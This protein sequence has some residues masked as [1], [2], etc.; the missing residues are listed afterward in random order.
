MKEGEVVK[1]NLIEGGKF[2]KQDGII[3]KN[4]IPS[5]EKKFSLSRNLLIGLGIF[6][7]LILIV[8]GIFFINYLNS[9]EQELDLGANIEG[10]VFNEKLNNVF[11]KLEGGSNDKVITKIKFIFKDADG[12]EYFYET[13]EGIKEISIPYK[14]GFWDFIRKPK[15]SGVYDYNINIGDILNLVDFKEIANVVVV[16]E[17]EEDG[18][19]IETPPLDDKPK[20]I[21]SGGNDDNGGYNGPDTGNKGCADESVEVTCSNVFCG[22]KNN[23]CKAP[24]NCTDVSGFLGDGLNCTNGIWLDESKNCTDY[25]DNYW[26]KDYAYNGSLFSD[27]CLDDSNLSEFLCDCTGNCFG[28]SIN[29]TNVTYECNEG[30]VN[31]ACVCTNECVEEGNYCEDD[32][33]SVYNCVLNKTTGC[34]KKEFVEDCTLSVLV[35]SAGECIEETGICNDIDGD[36]YGVYPNFNILNGC[37]KDGRDCNDTEISGVNIHPG[38][39]ESCNGIDDDCSGVADDYDFGQTT[40]GLG[41]CDHTINNCFAGETQTCDPFEGVGVELCDTLRLDEDCDGSDNEECPCD[42]GDSEDCGDNDVGECEFGTATCDING[43][44]GDCIGAIN[45]SPEVCD[46]ADNDCDEMIDEDDLGTILTQNCYEGPIDTEGIGLCI[47]GTQTCTLGSYLNTICAGQILPGVELCDVELLDEDCDD[48]NNEDCICIPGT[49]FPCGTDVG[50]CVSGNYVCQPD[51]RWGEVCEGEIAPVPEVCD[52]LDNDCTGVADDA[53]FGQT[54]CGEGECYNTIDNCIGGL[55]QTC[56]PF[57]GAVPEVC[58]GLL[59]ED[60]DG[61]V[62]NDCEC[63]I[64]S[65]LPCGTDVGLCVSGIYVCQSD[66]TWGDVCEGEIAPVPEVCDGLDNDCNGIDDNNPTDCS[67]D[68]CIAGDCV[69]CIID[70]DCDP[71]NTI[72]CS[73]S[74]TCSAPGN[75]EECGGW[76]DWGC[77]YGDCHNLG[78]CY[79]DNNIWPFANDC[80]DTS[81]VC[82]S[83]S[84]CEDYSDDECAD[85]PCVLI[86]ASGECVFDGTSCITCIDGDSDGWNS[87]AECNYNGEVDCDD[88]N[89]LVYPGAPE[90]CD[91]I[92]NDCNPL[93]GDICDPDSEV[94][95][96]GLDDD[97][98]TYVDQCDADCNLDS[99]IINSANPPY[100][101]IAEICNDE[102]DNDCNGLTNEGCDVPVPSAHWEFEGDYSDSVGPY[103]GSPIINPGFAPGKNGQA[104]SLPN[105]GTSYVDFGDVLDLTNEFTL[106]AWV[107]WED[108]G[109]FSA[110]I[111][112]KEMIDPL[113]PESPHQFNFEIRGDAGKDQLR[114]LSHDLEPN[115]IYSSDNSIPYNQ[116]THVA[117][118]FDGTNRKVFVNGM[119][120]SSDSASGTILENSET[121]KIGYGMGTGD[122]NNYFYGMIDDVM[123]YEE[124]LSEMEVRDIYCAQGGNCQCD[125]TNARWSKDG[126]NPLV[127]VGDS[128]DLIVDASDP[129][130]CYGKLINYTIWENDG[131]NPLFSLL[132][133]D[134]FVLSKI[135]SFDRTN[136]ITELESDY[137]NPEY[138]FTARLV[139]SEEE[140]TSGELIV[141]PCQ[142]NDGDGWNSTLGCNNGAGYDCNDIPGEGEGINPGALETCNTVDD[143]C[144]GIDDNNVVDCAEGE[145]CINGDCVKEEIYYVSKSGAGDGSEGNPDNLEGA[146]SHSY[147]HKGEEITYLLAPGDYGQFIYA[148]E[149]YYESMETPLGPEHKWHTWRSQDSD[150]PATFSV[151]IPCSGSACRAVKLGNEGGPNSKIAYIFDGIKVRGSFNIFSGIG[152]KILNSDLGGDPGKF[153]DFVVMA[154]KTNNNVGDILVENCYL[155]H[156]SIQMLATKGYDVYIKN[157]HFYY[158]LDDFVSLAGGDYFVV[159]GNTFDYSTHVIGVH[160]DG[161]QLYMDATL[162]GPMKNIF[163]RNNTFSRNA[164]QGIFC[165]G[166][167][168]YMNNLVIEYNLIYDNGGVPLVVGSATD[169]IVR[170]NT[171][172]GGASAHLAGNMDFSDNLFV[173]PV[174]TYG[175]VSTYFNSD[176]GHNVYFAGGTT[177]AYTI[178]TPLPTDIILT[179]S[180]EEQINEIFE[181]PSLNDYR[182]KPGSIA[183]SS[184]YPDG[185]AG[186]F[187]CGDSEPREICNVVGDEEGDGDA[188]CLDSD[189]FREMGPYGKICCGTISDCSICQECSSNECDDITASDGY[190]CADPG[191]YCDAGVCCND[192]N[193]DGVCDSPDL[194]TFIDS[195]L[196]NTLDVSSLPNYPRSYDGNTWF[197]RTG[198]YDYQHPYLWTLGFFPGALWEMYNLTSDN[199]WITNAGSWTDGLSSHKDNTYTHDLGFMFSNSNIKA[200]EYT[201]DSS[202]KADAITAAETLALRYKSGAQIIDAA[203]WNPTSFDNR[204]IIDSAMNLELLFWAEKN[205]ANCGDVSCYDIA[206][207][208]AAKMAADIVR[209]DGSTY[210]SVGYSDDGVLQGEATWQGYS[211][212]STWARGQAWGLYGYTMIYRET[213]DVSFLTTAEEIANYFIN[214]LPADYVPYW[215]FD[216]GL[217]DSSTDRDSSAAAIAASGLLELSHVEGLA[218][219]SIKAQ[220]YLTAANNI[221]NSLEANYLSE[222][223]HGILRDGVGNH[224][225]AREGVADE[226]E[227]GVSL[228]YGDMYFVEAINRRDNGFAYDCIGADCDPDPGCESDNECV[229]RG[230]ECIGTSYYDYPD[231]GICLESGT[232]NIGTG[233][234]E[235][236]APIITSNHP[237]CPDSGECVVADSAAWNN[238]VI[239]LEENL[240]TIEFDATVNQTGANSIFALSDGAQNTFGAFSVIVRFDHITNEI[241]AH[242]GGYTND[243]AIPYSADTSYH[244][245]IDTDVMSNTYDVY[246][247]DVQLANDYAFRDDVNNNINKID[248]WAIEAEIGSMEV[249]NVEISESSPPPACDLIDAYWSETGRDPEPPVVEGQIV[250]MIVEGNNNN[251]IGKAITYTIYENDFFWDDLVGTFDSESWTTKRIP[252]GIGDPEY[253]FTATLVED[254]TKTI[255]SVVT[256]KVSELECIDGDKDGYND[257]SFGC[258][259][260]ANVDCVDNNNAIHPGALEVCNGFDDDCN[261]LTDE[262]FSNCVGDEI[263]F[264]GDC[265]EDPCAGK[266]CGDFSVDEPTCLNNGCGLN[267]EWDGV[268]CQK[269]IEVIYYV[270]RDG[271][272]LPRNGNKGNEFTLAEA[273]DHSEAN[274]RSANPSEITYELKGEDYGVFD[275]DGIYDTPG[276]PGDVLLNLIYTGAW[277]T[278]RSANGETAIFSCS[279]NC[280]AVEIG[281]L[282]TSKVYRI[283]YIFDNIK[284]VG[285]FKT[286][287]AFGLK[288][289]NSEIMGT[290]GY[291]PTAYG[292]LTLGSSN[293]ESGDI[294]VDKCYIHH[295]K[296]DG[297][298]VKGFNFHIKNSKMRSPGSDLIKLNGIINLVIENNDFGGVDRWNTLGDDRRSTCCDVNFKDIPECAYRDYNSCSHPDIIQFYNG[299]C[300]NLLIRNN[301]FFGVPVQGI[302]VNSPTSNVIL[303]YN[304]FYDSDYPIKFQTSTSDIVIRY[305]TIVQKDDNLGA[306]MARVCNYGSNIDVYNN[307]FAIPYSGAS[308][309]TALDY[310]DYNIWIAHTSTPSPGPSEPHSYG[311][312]KSTLLADFKVGGENVFVDYANDN[313]APN[314]NGI[315]CDKNLFPNGV[316]AFPCGDPTCPGIDTSCG[317]DPDNCANCNLND[318]CT[319]DDYYDYYCDNNACDVEIT[320]NDPQ[321]TGL[322]LGTINSCGDSYPDCDDCENMTGCVEDVFRSYTK[323]ENYACVYEEFRFNTEIGKCN[324]GHDSDCDDLTDCDDEDDCGEDDACGIPNDYVAHWKFNGVID[325]VI[326]DETG[327][328]DGDLIN[329]AV[330]IDDVERG[331]KVLSLPNGGTSY[332]DMGD[333]LDMEGP[334]TLSTWVNWE[335][336]SDPYAG[337]IIGKEIGSGLQYNLEIR[338]DNG[339]KLRFISD[340]GANLYSNDPISKNTW[341]H[342]VFSFDGSV[343]KFYVNGVENGQGGMSGLTANDDS[344]K[345][346]YGQGTGANNNYLYGMVDDVAIYDRALSG[347]EIMDELYCKQ[348][349]SCVAS[350]NPLNGISEWFDNLLN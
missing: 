341:T 303:E 118:S 224:G 163:I 110:T 228:I 164:V 87:T 41:E 314:Q 318:G 129:D 167:P 48:L 100:V 12:N 229:C 128:V 199:K 4:S 262:E 16:F 321:C 307:L 153:V 312:D 310:H 1:T 102:Y 140:F 189:C 276:A 82:L 161:I 28:D 126:V 288:L 141:S 30:C 268:A 338:K 222:W 250:E 247:D 296:E 241:Q 39:I 306:A 337:T 259:G 157:N 192:D 298:S 201:G 180:V 336:S 43:V 168:T 143:N 170:H 231:F 291:L 115:T 239:P 145:S 285:F 6:G 331:S 146:R 27:V 218:G 248:N 24:V 330:I 15:F 257:T 281:P 62:D 263:C 105:G 284:V 151:P 185:Y 34:N 287:S 18:D 215:D 202:Y 273:M 120:D 293:Y 294:L 295:V 50:L 187:P 121:L 244:F 323:C 226:S 324:D 297:I 8:I 308:W 221:L 125:L 3:L 246:V 99:N 61:R 210:H 44:M 64:G 112:G 183:C 60:C 175:G 66:G 235:G 329:G 158:A 73:P 142:D 117:V 343:G 133:P 173:N 68:H 20:P 184:N 84:Q 227:V 325:N 333:V 203:V 265:V 85:D 111:I 70:S 193:D 166:P 32:S 348:G 339:E 212:E 278:W 267:C 195:Q 233:D 237:A 269:K 305:N 309:E 176:S 45:P 245:K 236:C 258:G 181:N 25:V 219:N 71:A 21:P 135:G 63:I 283:G 172:V 286:S 214:N 315:A 11:I 154:G 198:T 349:G 37:E 47:G 144:D 256:L 79:F 182:P 93:T 344:F 200:Y 190:N 340:E 322:C 137:G 282:D 316:G 264:E 313:Y 208:H 97:I 123:V 150:Y 350:F 58:E 107:N 131:D 186:A 271:G 234:V 38:M 139:G 159:E 94:C 277:H 289:I 261:D 162:D 260:D 127:I 188:D 345:I 119:L 57:L 101:A 65:E 196:T 52:G 124:G 169:I 328:Y 78:S 266:E 177:G 49:E 230:D 10:I 223:S 320:P 74:N 206:V 114:F 232:C 132:N 113:E 86:S 254:P 77:S 88:G 209:D 109:T 76:L 272:T 14:K 51:G 138:V 136:W 216:Y 300:R 252:D 116:W 92:D 213:G 270:T 36:G 103:G 19:I 90:L 225:E 332:V 217:I 147:D 148:G 171:I 197:L 211:D 207:N 242:N 33:N 179:G 29:I 249:C 42:Q 253:Y 122:S 134:D 255:T 2:V 317:L 106:S 342:V 240:F 326:P 346:G 149:R 302:F 156:S 334:F 23:N 5:K 35:C 130:G 9:P 204:V 95:G 251:C 96:N 275:Y 279:G 91:G 290:S 160:N 152:V 26:V 31:G 89:N 327:N 69:D 347:N 80:T 319:G 104:L 56:N 165:G 72:F 83:I 205:G 178:F 220:T 75:C 98:D 311:F 59:D 299:E 108:Y 292:G 335:D 53:D 191:K 304:L 174:G 243:V 194:L 274:L 7:L 301:T 81:I 13:S 280:N 155:H 67:E 238:N 22:I 40:C 17:Y 46:G 54:T 55:P